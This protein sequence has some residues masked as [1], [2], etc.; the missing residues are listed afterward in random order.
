MSNLAEQLLESASAVAALGS[1]PEDIAA[2]DDASVLEGMK[3]VT[4]HRR[5]LQAYEV[6]LSSEIAKRSSHEFGNSGLARS[7][8][9]AT[10]A[11]LIQSLTGGSIDEATKL[12]RMG[13]VVAIAEQEASALA[14]A[15]HGAVGADDAG[16]AHPGLGPS[17]LGPSHLGPLDPGPLGLGPLD[18]MPTD[19]APTDPVLANSQ[20]PSVSPLAT[21]AVTGDISLAAADAIRKGLGKPDA[22]IT[23]EQLRVAEAKLLRDAGRVSP[24]ALLKLARVARSELDL[25]AVARG[26]KKRAQ[27]RYVRTWQRDGMSGGSWSIPDED[28]G[29]DINTAFKLMLASRAGGPR[30]PQTDEAGNPI[31][32]TA[33]EIQLD[34][35]RTFEQVLADGFVQVFQNGLRVDPSVVPAAGRAPVRV[36]VTDKVLM[37][38]RGMASIEGSLSKVTFEKL[39]EHLCEGGQLGVL[40]DRNGNLIDVG[41]EQR[42]FTKRQRT[43]LAVRDGGCRYP[44]CDKP[45]SWTEAHHILQWARDHGRTDVINAILLCRYH[46]M[47][48]HELGAEI[49]QDGAK[50]W[51]KLPKSMDP[52]QTLIEMPSKNP[53]IAAMVNADAN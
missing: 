6:L 38:Q 8:G 9:S 30:F 11:I 22:A 24:E 7:N 33:A 14:D 39:E 15:G 49:I 36:I 44:G 16:A 51:L 4:A 35:T 1:A 18:P 21:A 40:F 37:E 20:Q 50:Y 10:P 5:G 26:Q 29:A 12:A 53:I 46:H 43:G 13:E 52:A 34:D 19:P 3:L 2:L 48:I 23:I 45:P 28:G 31:R 25:E 41:R 27:L 32:K 47:L 17:D 42:L